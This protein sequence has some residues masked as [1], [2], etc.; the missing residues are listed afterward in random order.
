M[1]SG[2]LV[3]TYTDGTVDTCKENDLFYLQPGH[4][5]RPVKDS[6]VILFSPLCEHE[7]AMDHMPNAMGC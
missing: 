4:S 3:V 6:E 1:I 7:L 2:E 5:V